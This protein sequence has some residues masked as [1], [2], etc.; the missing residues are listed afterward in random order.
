MRVPLLLRTLFSRPDLA[1]K[2]QELRFDIHPGFKTTPHEWVKF[3]EYVCVYKG[4]IDMCLKEVQKM[5]IYEPRKKILELD[6]IHQWPVAMMGVVLNLVSNLKHL[7]IDQHYAGDAMDYL[8]GKVQD[9]GGQH[10]SEYWDYRDPHVGS[11]IEGIANLPG[12]ARLRTLRLEM[13]AKTVRFD[14]LRAFVPPV[15]TLDLLLLPYHWDL[16]L[17]G[18]ASGTSTVPGG[19]PPLSN[20]LR[21]VTH[22]RI[23]GRIQQVELRAGQFLGHLQHILLANRPLRNLEVY[24]EPPSYQFGLL[25]RSDHQGPFPDHR[26]GLYKSSFLGSTFQD[27]LAALSPLRP[28]LTTLKMPRG[29]WTLRRVDPVPGAC[30]AN[31]SQLEELD[32]PKE[33]LV[34]T[35]RNRDPQYEKLVQA[36][37][38]PGKADEP[39]PTSIVEQLPRSLR[40]LAIFDMDASASKWIDKLLSVSRTGLP[41]LTILKLGFVRGIAVDEK[42]RILEKVEEAAAETMVTVEVVE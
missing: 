38:T 17:A 3:R 14:S 31:M 29:F 1:R 30:F 37:Q 21:A 27:L 28:S 15:E 33:M 26:Y 39:E 41:E 18:L 32:V 4:V 24:G 35:P 16:F 19:T 22:L 20:S 2:V 7:T 8:F 11:R 9:W 5:P 6:L 34:G 42:E 36:H 10:F 23:D 13:A 12:V 25:L 40:V